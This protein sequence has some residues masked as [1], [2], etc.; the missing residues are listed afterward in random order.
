MVFFNRGFACFGWARELDLSGTG[1]ALSEAADPLDPFSE[2]AQSKLAG[3]DALQRGQT[4]GTI[5]DLN[6]DGVQDLLGVDLEN[7]VWVLFGAREAGRALGLTI[8]LSP[9]VSNPVT[10]AIRGKGRCLGMHVVRPGM[11][12]FAGRAVPGPLDL[13]WNGPDGE[14]RTQRA[15]VVKPIRVELGP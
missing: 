12:A 2:P 8:T 10:V 5:W 4:T 1:S 3:A 15:I 6:G 14:A 11:P 13:Q 7:N 9:K